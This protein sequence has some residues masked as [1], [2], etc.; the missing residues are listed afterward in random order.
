MKYL[1]GI[2]ELYKAWHSDTIIYSFS[3]LL[4]IFVEYQQ[5]KQ[6]KTINISWIEM[7]VRVATEPLCG[8]PPGVAVWLERGDS[9]INGPSVCNGEECGCQPGIWVSRPCPGDEHF[10]LCQVGLPVQGTAGGGGTSL[11]SHLLTFKGARTHVHQC[12]RVCALEHSC[13]WERD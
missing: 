6:S 8:S 9:G 1:S 11:V 5:T 13:I 3:C 7:S 2:H 4:F 12:T 10:T